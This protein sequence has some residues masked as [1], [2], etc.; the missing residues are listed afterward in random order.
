MARLE[1]VGSPA[2]TA[3]DNY[4]EFD[5]TDDG[6]DDSD[7]DEALLPV[8]MRR[9]ETVT[10]ALETR[11]EAVAAALRDL[12]VVMM[13]ADRAH[14]ASRTHAHEPLVHGDRQALCLRPGHLQDEG[15]VR[16]VRAT[17]GT[18][19]GLVLAT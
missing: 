11:V 12:R 3:P 10:P 18:F 17:R 8:L 15:I 16:P 1:D 9:P 19:R 5:V 2:P 6:G 13:T 14:R 4:K 7:D